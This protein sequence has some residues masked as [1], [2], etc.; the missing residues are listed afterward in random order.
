MPFADS[1]ETNEIAFH[2]SQSEPTASGVT[3]DI[4]PEVMAH[5]KGEDDAEESKAT[6]SPTVSVN[7]ASSTDE[8]PV[9]TR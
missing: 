6:E 4:H 7:L 9:S 8:A 1:S 2:E 5:A 3:E